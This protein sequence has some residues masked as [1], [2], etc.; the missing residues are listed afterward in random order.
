ML[1]TPQTTFTQCS[2]CPNDTGASWKTLC[3]SCWRNRSPEEIRT[4]RQE[5][6]DRKV[7]R[8]RKYADSRDSKAETQM[9][10][11]NMYRKDLSWLT[12]PNI[13]TAAGRAFA[14]SRQRVID[15]YDAGM[16]LSIEADDMRSKAEW[17]EKQGAVVKGDAERKRQAKREEIDA[18]VNIGDIVHHFLYDD[19]EILKKNVKTFTVKVIR[20][21]SVFT[22]EKS[23]IEKPIREEVS[24]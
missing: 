21:G 14:R 4:Q 6:L 18:L 7:A 16:R 5:K 20:S 22:V 1:M 15:R 17:L 10:S 9:S 23:H 13:P 8:L 3:I 24:K 19:V 11:F 2:K 12:Q